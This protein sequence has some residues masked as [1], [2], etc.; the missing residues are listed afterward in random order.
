[1]QM[2]ARS[3]RISLWIIDDVGKA[4]WLK[5]AESGFDFFTRPPIEIFHGLRT[6]RIPT[7]GCILWTNMVLILIIS[8]LDQKLWKCVGIESFYPSTP[9]TYYPYCAVL[10]LSGFW[11]WGV[12]QTA[13][14]LKLTRRLTTVFSHAGLKNSLG[15]F[16][17]FISDYPIDEFTRKLRLGRNGFSK[18]Q[19][20]KAKSSLESNLQVYI[21]EF[22]ES[23]EHG[24]IDIIYSHSPMPE[25]T[26]IDD[27]GKLAPLTFV[28]GKT[29]AQQIVASLKEVPHLMI[30]GQTGGGK[31]TFLRGLITAL[32]LNNRDFEFTLIDLKGGLEFQTFENLKRVEVV[33]NVSQAVTALKTLGTLL[34]DRMALLK[35][36]ECKDIDAY[37]A[38]PPEERKLAR[39]EDGSAPLGRHVLVVDEAAE[40]FLAG[41]HADANEI[42]TARRIL[43]QIARQGRAV[44][45]HLVIATQRPDAK[46]LDPQVKA[47]LTGVLCFQMLNDA[48]SITVLGVGRATEL[49]AIPGRAIWKSGSKMIEVQTP[50]LSAETA[51]QLLEP[52]RLSHKPAPRG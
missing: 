36:N 22:R 40:M 24:T 5:V 32:F 14:R 30:A 1:M 19:F 8:R 33:P 41:S 25:L 43:S 15:R 37:L 16:P 7:D 2:E 18:D 51:D 45:V 20:E 13:L 6:K 17:S 38:L 23:R 34:E 27:I 10:A 4:V 42:Q 31:S 3:K 21:D 29:R 49:P 11:C 39:G 12:F 9:L 44:G 50:Y 28:I 52:Q 46:S 48:S 47:N 26:H 35:T